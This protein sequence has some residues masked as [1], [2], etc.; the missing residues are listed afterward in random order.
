MVVSATQYGFQAAGV[1]HAQCAG[2]QLF[3]RGLA[4]LLFSPIREG[5]EA[6]GELAA[7]QAGFAFLLTFLS[8][9]LPA[10]LSPFGQDILIK[11]GLFK[12]DVG[13]A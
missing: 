5:A 12:V 7:E 8:A 11:A 1:Q 6:Q 13:N 2:F 4:K 9:F 3:S 10:F